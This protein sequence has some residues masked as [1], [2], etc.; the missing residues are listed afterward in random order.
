MRKLIKEVVLHAIRIIR[1]NR[2]IELL[3][4]FCDEVKVWQ[5]NQEIQGK[6][7]FIRQGEG[8]I[9]IEGD[10][11][12]FSI[13]ETS[14]LKGGAYI[15]CNGGVT[16]GRYFHCGKDLTILSTNHRYE[17]AESIPYDAVYIKKPVVIEDFVWCGANVTIVPGVTVGEGAIIAAGSVVTKDVPRCA[18]VGGNP[19]KVIKYRDQEAFDRLKK[20][21]KFY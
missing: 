8:G 4:C 16:I 7:N 19:A 20:E 5:Y 21:E 15:E 6:L 17:G 3:K 10:L 2:M 9:T 12:R 1:M 13:H 11:S 14:H 18:I